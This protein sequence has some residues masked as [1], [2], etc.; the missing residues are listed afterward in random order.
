VAKRHEKVGI[1]DHEEECPSEVPTAHSVS[2]RSAATGSSQK[3]ESA[4]EVQITEL[5]SPRSAITETPKLTPRMTPPGSPRPAKSA[6][7]EKMPF[8][9]RRSS[10]VSFVENMG[11]DDDSDI[12]LNAFEE[13]IHDSSTHSVTTTARLQEDSPHT[14]SLVHLGESDNE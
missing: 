12:E 8:K 5:T 14:P 9:S 10:R 11:L 4:S 1:A 13:L 3:D 7:A 2:P 6:L